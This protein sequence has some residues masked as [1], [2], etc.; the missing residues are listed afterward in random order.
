[1]TA[2]LAVHGIATPGVLVGVNGVTKAAGGLSLPVGA[3]LL[4]LTALPALRRTRDI[5]PLVALQLTTAVAVVALGAFGLAVPSAV[6]AVPAAGS[7]LA[8]ALVAGGLACVGLTLAVA[9]VVPRFLR[10]DARDPHP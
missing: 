10:Y 1:M 8:W 5:A 3:A 6:P 2:L 9:S 7:P 4:A